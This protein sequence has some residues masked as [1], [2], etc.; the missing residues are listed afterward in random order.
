MT[1]LITS[2]LTWC[3][4]KAMCFPLAEICLLVASDFSAVLSI[5]TLLPSKLMSLRQGSLFA[6]AH[7]NLRLQVICFP[8]SDNAIY[9]ESTEDNA[10][11]VYLLV[12][13]EIGVPLMVITEPVVIYVY[14]YIRPNQRQRGQLSSADSESGRI[15][16]I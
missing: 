12:R 3:F 16:D 11:I 4:L 5:K 2:P 6:T 7:Y 8:H 13:D 10:I 14:L 9:S 1:L 15:E